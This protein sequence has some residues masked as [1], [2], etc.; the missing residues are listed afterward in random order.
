MLRV[1]LQSGFHKVLGV[2]QRE[3]VTHVENFAHVD[4]QQLQAAGEGHPEKLHLLPV[5]LREAPVSQ[6]SGEVSAGGRGQV[7]GLPSR[8]PQLLPQRRAVRA[9]ANTGGQLTVT[10]HHLQERGTGKRRIYRRVHHLINEE[11]GH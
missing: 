2:G 7:L 4:V 11:V 10:R 8:L 5:L 3:D 9:A 1:T 6:V